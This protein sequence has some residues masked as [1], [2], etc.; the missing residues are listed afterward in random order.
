M[1]SIRS[2]ALLALLG[3]VLLPVWM[4]LGA[5]P[6][7]ESETDQITVQ[8]GVPTKP[9][10]QTPVP[11]V[12]RIDKATVERYG[13]E[14]YNVDR[15]VNQMVLG[16]RVRGDSRTV[17]RSHTVMVPNPEVATFDIVF[18]GRTTTTT[19]SV[20]EPGVVYG[21][22]LTEMCCT[23][24]VVFDPKQG[25]VVQ[26]TTECKGNTQL[27]LDGFGSTRQFGQRLITRITERQARQQFEQAR[28]IADH[29][30]KLDVR[31]E[32]E[33]EVDKSL[34]EAGKG[35]NLERLAE[36]FFGKDSDLT[37]YTKSDADAIHIGLGPA[38]EK[39]AALT[40]LPPRQPNS[41]GIEVFVH[42]SILSN[43]VAAALKLVTPEEKVTLVEHSTIFGNLK[44]LP[45]SVN[46]TADVALQ[47]G[48]LVLGLPE[49]DAPTTA[50]TDTGTRRK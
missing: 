49:A 39:N 14:D 34:A 19:V 16:A 9:P 6:N 40:R 7:P 21:R 46:S 3:F 31:V 26:G 18:Q 27:F 47:D 13:S 2:L 25:F 12:V 42:A 41:P 36:Q 35:L 32:F 4:T 33:K 50:A 15:P 48:W 8:G 43:P 38:K 22:T 45:S 23:R 29:D 17:G 24:R 10:E 37:F 30:N 20:K 44:I 1:S 5:D 11:L 28:Q